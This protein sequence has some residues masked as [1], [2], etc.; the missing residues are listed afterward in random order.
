MKFH[1]KTGKYTERWL[2]KS[3]LTKSFSYMS[4]TR[5]QYQRQISR[6]AWWYRLLIKIM[7][8]LK[9]EEYNKFISSLDNF[10]R[11]T[12]SDNRKGKRA[13]DTAEQWTVVRM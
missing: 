12:L 10:W 13:K 8:T 7:K 11:Q 9:Q 5:S 4:N 1:Q 6:W 3:T 2:T